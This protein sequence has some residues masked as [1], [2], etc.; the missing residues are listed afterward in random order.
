MGKKVKN[1]SVKKSFWSDGISDREFIMMVSV[2]T[3]FFF[4]ALGMAMSLW[5][6]VNETY[7]E[8]LKMTVHPLTIIIGSVFAIEG[9]E[10]FTDR[11][12]KN[13]IGSLV[14]KKV[15]TSAEAVEVTD[16]VIRD[17]Q[18]HKPEEEDIV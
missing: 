2:A 14:E 6:T 8:I 7:M 5:I 13:E 1:K 12:T 17:I 15:D 16:S 3:F 9:V 4:A 10:K 11:K 18:G